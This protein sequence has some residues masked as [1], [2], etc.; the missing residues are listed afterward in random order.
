[1]QSAIYQGKVFHQRFRPT[2]HAF[3]YAMYLFW[4]KLDEIEQIC[5]TVKHVSQS[6]FSLVQFRRSDY[7]GEPKDSLA[8]AVRKK[9]SSLNGSELIGDVFLLGQLRMLGFYFSPVNF[10]FLRSPEGKFS[11][12]LAEVSNTPWH[13]THCYLVDLAAQNDSKKAFHVSPFNPMNMIYKWR[14]SN[15]ADKLSIALDC[16]HNEKDFS[17]GLVLQRQPLTTRNLRKCLT[18]IPSMTIKTVLGIYFQ[19]L[20]LW[21][22]GTPLHS[23]P[24]QNNGTIDGD[25]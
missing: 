24:S 25:K 5:Q 22:K 11:H 17:A 16:H 1:M 8:D 20:K 9:M 6:R 19:A 13:E 3:N 21:I 14:I 2:Q 15:P 23:H 18:K 12:M 4:L 10:Y 7:L